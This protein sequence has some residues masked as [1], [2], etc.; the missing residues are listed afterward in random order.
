MII[1]IWFDQRSPISSEIYVDIC[2]FFV[3]F[4]FLLKCGLTSFQT[5]SGDDLPSRSAVSISQERTG[6]QCKKSLNL[7]FQKISN[8][9]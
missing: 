9:S 4:C 6:I 3:L 7:L 1:F 8:D 5:S 2:C